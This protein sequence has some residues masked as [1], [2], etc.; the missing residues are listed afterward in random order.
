V[1]LAQKAAEARAKM[2]Q[3]NP[4]QDA[5]KPAAE[6]R[7]IPLSVPQR[8]LEVPDIPGYHLRWIRGTAQRL[9]QADRAGFEMNDL[10]LGGD[11]AK[12]GNTDM[13]SRVS[14]AEGSE[15][16]SG[17]QAVR[18]Y[19][20]KQKLEYYKEDQEIIQKRNDSVAEA[21]TASYTQGVVGGQAQGETKEDLGLR[22]VDKTR[23]R[24]PE[25]FRKKGPKSR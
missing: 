12:T 19:L 16:D 21:L 6:R 15:V 22:Y 17:G 5:A 7:R 4:G 18:L 14:V 1:D 23:S 2:D 9:L 13:G 11:G 25:M 8:K 3:Q 10:A 20:M 24:V